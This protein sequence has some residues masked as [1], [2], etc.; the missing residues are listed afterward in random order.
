MTKEEDSEWFCFQ[1]QTSVLPMNVIP[2]SEAV[3]KVFFENGLTNSNQYDI[4]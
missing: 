2:A 1:L 4:V 3:E